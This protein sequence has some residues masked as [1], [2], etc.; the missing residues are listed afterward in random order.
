MRG[1][2]LHRCATSARLGGEFYGALPQRFRGRSSLGKLIT[3][4]SPAARYSPPM[5]EL[6][7]EP[8]PSFRRQRCMALNAPAALVRRR[9]GLPRSE[10]KRRAVELSAAV[11]RQ[12][13]MTRLRVFAVSLAAVVLAVVAALM[14]AAADGEPLALEIDASPR[15]CTAGSLAKVT[16]LIRGGEGPYRL[17]I[18]G[19][20]V[21]ADAE[22]ATVRCGSGLGDAP[23]WLS[24]AARQMTIRAEV[25]DAA[26]ATARADATLVPALP[27]PPPS[28]VS[29][30]IGQDWGDYRLAAISTRIETV[31]RRLSPRTDAAAF[32]TRRYIA[33]WRERGASSWSY[34]EFDGGREDRYPSHS[35]EAPPGMINVQYYY[36]IFGLRAGTFYELQ[37]SRM[38]DPLERETPDALRWSSPQT[39]VSKGPP[40]DVTAHVTR[41]SI[42]V[43]W[44]S[45]RESTEWYILLAALQPSPD[46]QR[47]GYPHVG[48]KSV[49]GSSSYAVRFDDLI[50]GH[51]YNIHIRQ[52]HE[53]VLA[54]A[55]FDIRTEGAASAA[56]L[57]EHRPTITRAEVVDGVL[58]VEWL[59]SE[60]EPARRHYVTARD[61]A[62]GDNGSSVV[63]EDG[64][65]HASFSDF[66]PGATY[67]VAVEAI[68]GYRERDERIIET[69]LDS[70]EDRA[71]RDLRTPRISVEWVQFHDPYEIFLVS[72]EPV[73]G[74]EI[75]QVKW[76]RDG[77]MASSL[78]K[79]PIAIKADQPGR[80]VFRARLKL[81]DGWSGWT[82]MIEAT[83][84]PGPPK[85]VRTR[86]LA[87]ALLIEWEPGPEGTP[88]D[89]YR[90]YYERSGEPER[91]FTVRDG[92]SL[93]IPVAHSCR[94]YIVR[95]AAFSDEFGEGPLSPHDIR[96]EAAC[97]QLSIAVGSF[98][99]TCDD[100][101]GAST[102]VTWTISGGATPYTI[103]A[104]GHEPV[105]SNDS[106]GWL[107]INCPTES[108][109]AARTIPVLITDALGETAAAQIEL[110]EL[111]TALPDYVRVREG[112]YSVE[113]TGLRAMRVFREEVRLSWRCVAW[114]ERSWW[115]TDVPPPTFLLR[116]RN[117]ES[118]EWT[119][120]NATATPMA[121]KVDN[122]CHW[123]WSEL[124][125]G[126][127]YEFQLATW[128]HLDELD[129]PERLS[130][131]PLQSVT[132]LGA[133]ENVRI[134]RDD[135]AIV[136]SWAAQPHAW[137]YQIVLRGREESWW[138]YYLPS[139]GDAE[140]AIFNGA[141]LNGRYDV[142]I[143]TPPRVAGIPQRDPGLIMPAP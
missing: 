131:S 116:W 68:D 108:E 88:A 99:A 12:A 1:V 3:I 40:Q 119:Y 130:W 124:A 95:V 64:A 112:A 38:R 54:E 143:T 121:R 80:Y 10:E 81:L 8:A 5:P 29:A 53:M 52:L 26:G 98:P 85:D 41:D 106:R 2:G 60:V 100:Q 103:V 129:E 62:A 55:V 102:V 7:L 24:E 133:P 97:E 113:I 46:G 134:S 14:P 49:A 93:T 4:F 9:A 17:A 127:R 27:L 104:Q 83:T 96:S 78:G 87:D 15:T 101:L 23:A 84:K 76:G 117:A 57:A 92:V 50:P 94:T 114:V 136:V 42:T 48:G 140:R 132:T 39:L 77:Q 86:A 111:A 110:V 120:I 107:R 126:T 66:T 33:R 105:R 16:W 72:W 43:S 18:D 19:E 89:G 91:V 22:S 32:G 31:E 115:G 51:G 21:D 90:I 142:E 47:T 56:A 141:P 35:N 61:S 135:G 74:A 82:G 67:R 65:T 6:P 125:P 79:S 75:A 123:T 34:G 73:D 25:V 69:P 138:K 70:P 44:R 45:N 122:G 71:W 128:L 11:R 13:G 118:S 28:R 137:A 36:P 109:G 30:Y 63:A 59:P 37:V 58:H 20:A 139:G